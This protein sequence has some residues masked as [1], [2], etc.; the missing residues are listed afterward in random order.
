MNPKR[1]VVAATSM[2]VVIRPWR[3]IRVSFGGAFGHP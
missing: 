2:G 3:V 1:G